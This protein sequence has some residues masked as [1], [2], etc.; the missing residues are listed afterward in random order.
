MVA[1]TRAALVGA[2]FSI[3]VAACGSATPT[4]SSSSAVAPPT[5]A[6][7]PSAVALPTATPA[8]APAGSR[9]PSSQQPSAVPS[10]GDV[11]SPPGTRTLQDFALADAG[12][13]ATGPFGL[14]EVASR[15]VVRID[16]S[17]GTVT[18]FGIG[19]GEGLADVAE[20]PTAI[21]VA[22]FD[23]SQVERV[24]PAS[25]AITS[26]DTGAASYV[27][28]VGKT[29]WVSDHHEGQVTRLDAATG[30]VI[31][32]TTLGPSGVNG[33]N[34]MALGD[35]SVWVEVPNRAEVVRMNPQTAKVTARI[36]V[37]ASF[38]DDSQLLVQ[39][40]AVWIDGGGNTPDIIRIDPR[41]NRV[42]ARITLD[43]LPGT[44]ALTSDPMAIG[45]GVWVATETPGPLELERIDPATNTVSA[46]VPF[47]GLDAAGPSIVADGYVW[48]ADGFGSLVA[49]P[50]GAL[51][52]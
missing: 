50:V 17:T 19:N 9:A 16:T 41:T 29:V 8:T 51:G 30:H 15:D 5:S 21:W 22:D 37:P 14:L 23:G 49:I 10:A 35:G 47:S 48:I 24:D 27:L 11:A 34:D 12:P 6:G 20:S 13:L 28:P 3:A 38:G 7:L 32:R 44:D 1:S 39:P 36:P 40:D 43:G 18:P 46:K 26:F 4:P 31:D 42:V 2:L 52:G 25:H 33:P 45:G